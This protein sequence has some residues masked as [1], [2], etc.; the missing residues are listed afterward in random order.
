MALPETPVAA[1]FFDGITAA[2]RA[3]DVAIG[4]DQRSLRFAGQV[5]PLDRLRRVAGSDPDEM[6]LT[7]HAEGAGIGEAPQD[8]ARLVLTDAAL[9]VWITDHTPDLARRD[10][11]P[12]TRGRV[13]TR[14]ALAAAALGLILFVF[15][16][17]ISDALADQLPLEQEVAFGRAVVGQI[18]SLLGDDSPLTCDAPAGRAALQRMEQRLTEGQGLRYD[19]DLAVFDHE[20]INAFAAPGGQIVIMRGLLDAAESPE[21]VAGVLA[22][23]IGHVEAR[24]PTRLAFRSAGSAGIIALLLGDVTGGTVIGLLGDHILTASYTREAETAADGFAFALLNRTGIGTE[25]L[26]SFFDRIE[27]MGGDIPEILSTHPTTGNR[28]EAARAAASTDG[29][30]VLTAAEW[31]DLRGICG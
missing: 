5:W 14:I 4:P 29:D 31:R 1:T 22:H 18:E 17:R 26:A 9:M 6:V 25:G 13:L 19:I 28:A 15:L 27:G 3:V 12:G 2:R 16:P 30:P 11:H 24:D 8:A 20:M 10:L 7:L 21:E 23:E